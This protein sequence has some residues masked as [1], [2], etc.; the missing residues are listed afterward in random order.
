MLHEFTFHGYV[1]ADTRF[2]LLLLLLPSLLLLLLL[3]LL[4]TGCSQLRH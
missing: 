4:L 2:L 1:V 3:L